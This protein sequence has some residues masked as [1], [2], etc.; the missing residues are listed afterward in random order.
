MKLSQAC[1]AIV[2]AMYSDETLYSIIPDK[3]EQTMVEV[4]YMPD[5]PCPRP[6]AY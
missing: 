2:I 6:T 1:L 5:L 3:F 4:T